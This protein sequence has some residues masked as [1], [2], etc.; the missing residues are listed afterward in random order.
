V[1][2]RALEREKKQDIG[3]VKI[4]KSKKGDGTSWGECERRISIS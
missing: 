2:H 4:N 3:R 1:P